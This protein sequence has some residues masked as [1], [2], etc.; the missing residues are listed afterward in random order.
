MNRMLS[1]R[2][3]ILS[4]LLVGLAGSVPEAG[5][6][7]AKEQGR[8]R[9]NLFSHVMTSA[10][11]D[12]AFA[13]IS[14]SWTVY[15]KPNHAVVFRVVSATGPWQTHPEADEFWFVRRGTAKV[16]L[17]EYTLASGVTPPGKTFDLAAGDVAYVPRNLAYQ[18]A[19]SAKVEYVAVRV[20]SSQ[21]RVSTQPAGAKPRVPRPAPNVV[22]GAQIAETFKTMA[23]SR[24][25][26]QPFHSAGAISIGQ[27][28]YDGAPGPWESH[29][30]TDQIYFVRSGTTRA[31]LDGYITDQAETGPGQVRGN[32]VTG[33]TEYVASAGDIIWVPRNTSHYMDP[34]KGR[35][36][37][38]LL[39]I[40]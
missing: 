18:I 2:V 37:Y 17:A 12:A 9:T 24:V 8:L 4:T 33:A 3:F 20:F 31:F 6:Q 32:G 40:N 11:I 34:G 1:I 10:E 30:I 26:S 14:E 38:L 19:A 35:F 29:E 5:Q 13:Q 15:T 25:K 16:S 39:T 23:D 27:N 7:A 28:L 21:A 36:G 22:P